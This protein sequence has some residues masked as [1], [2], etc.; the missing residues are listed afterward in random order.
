MDYSTKAILVL[1]LNIVLPGLGTIITVEDDP[2]TKNR[3]ILQLII[4]VGGIVLAAFTC[5]IT[6]L[7]SLGMWVWALIDGI[8]LMKKFNELA[9]QPPTAPPSPPTTPPS[10]SA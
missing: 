7:A 1:V 5:G 8:N 4:Y 9:K 3:G 2:K 10:P 6:A